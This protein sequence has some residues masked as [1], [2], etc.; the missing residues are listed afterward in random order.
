[1]IGEL[2]EAAGAERQAAL[3]REITKMHETFYRG[4]LQEIHDNITKQFSGDVKGECVLVVEGL[5]REKNSKNKEK[6]TEE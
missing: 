1:L 2:I 5:T 3:A 4:T 6:Y